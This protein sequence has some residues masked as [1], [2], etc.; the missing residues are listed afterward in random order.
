LFRR[1]YWRKAYILENTIG[2]LS[3]AV[4]SGCFLVRKCGNCGSNVENDKT[5]QCPYCSRTI[6]KRRLPAIR[7]I[8]TSISELVKMASGVIVL[9]LLVSL[10]LL[11]LTHA[12]SHS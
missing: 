6:E 4:G 1:T 10:F 12:F 3:L 5:V 11:W 8:L 2:R 9:C 7:N